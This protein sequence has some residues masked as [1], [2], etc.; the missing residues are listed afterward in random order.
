MTGGRAEGRE[1]TRVRAQLARRRRIGKEVRSGAGSGGWR[2]KLETAKGAGEG[3][4]AG[5][6]AVIWWK[7]KR[8]KDGRE[9]RWE[10]DEKK[11]H[12]RAREGEDLVGEGMSA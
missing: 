10:D 3:R 1:G 9:S 12:T 11:R 6:R 5:V 4:N 8:T 2:A 7:G